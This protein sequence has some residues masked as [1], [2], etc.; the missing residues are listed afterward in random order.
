MVAA[1]EQASGKKI[2]LVTAARRPGDAEI[3]Y[4]STEK[5]E[6]ELN[7]KAKYGVEEMC[8][9]QWNWASKNPYGYESSASK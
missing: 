2:P 7:W 5:A 8:R 4:A 1:F 3:L 9:D 6:R